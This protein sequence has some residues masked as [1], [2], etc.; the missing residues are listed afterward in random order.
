ME[1]PVPP[2]KARKLPAVLA[3]AVDFAAAACAAAVIVISLLDFFDVMDLEWFTSNAA[4][5]TL[6]LLSTL[7]IYSVLERRVS[8]DLRHQEAMTA[9]KA[10]MSD[11]LAAKLGASG[12]TNIYT[13]RTDYAK[14]RGHTELFDYLASARS[15]VHVLAHWLAHGVGIEGIGPKLADLVSERPDFVV[16]LCVVNPKGE[17]V[18]GLA[19][20]LGMTRNEVSSRARSSLDELWRAKQ[21]MPAEQQHRFV[22]KAYDSLPVASTIMLDVHQEDGKIQLDY[23]SFRTP[24]QNSFGI[25]IQRNGSG[26]YERY[27]AACLAQIDEADAFAGQTPGNEGS[28]G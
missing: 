5:I 18:G 12:V 27:A 26:L 8:L 28:D 3:A 1:A 10:L 21:R 11:R 14:Y 19:E 6:L 9:I 20:F 13:S 16:T 22:I 23:K 24:R 15:S 4:K 2:R 25:E 17:M 7:V